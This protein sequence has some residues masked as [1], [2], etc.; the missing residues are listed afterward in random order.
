MT[1]N[2][3]V[4]DNDEHGIPSPGA[5]EGGEIPAEAAPEGGLPVEPVESALDRVTAERDEL[6]D[7]HLR[8]AAEYD[9]FR[10]RS[11]RERAEWAERAQAELLGKL[12]E[13]LDDLDRV[14]EN[15]GK[16]ASVDDLH[17]AVTLVDRKLWK[18]L[19]KFGLEV[20]EPVGVP[21]DPSVHEAISQVAAPS[22]E[23]AHQVAATF[24]AG[25]RYKGI[26]LR[27]ARVQVYGEPA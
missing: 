2:K 23:Q 1:V 18:E 12:L 15:G 20:L 27:P 9:N 26:L 14:V 16:S 3:E 24:Q 19:E 21:F 7:R 13:V 10:K 4:M 11:Q 5:A 17:Q 22:A 25:Y 8:L 6:K